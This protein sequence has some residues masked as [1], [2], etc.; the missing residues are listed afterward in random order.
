VDDKFADRI[1]KN[2]RSRK[3]KPPDRIIYI[4]LISLSSKDYFLEKREQ[5]KPKQTIRK[6]I[7]ILEQKTKKIKGGVGKVAQDFSSKRKA[8]K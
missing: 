5:A 8:L 6:V 1:S 4:R 3:K 2:W 7:R